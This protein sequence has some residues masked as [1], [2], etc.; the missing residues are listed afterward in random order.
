MRMTED[1]TAEDGRRE[2]AFP[3]SS[4]LHPRSFLQTLDLVVARTGVERYRY[5]CL[6][7]PNSTVRA[8]YAALVVRLAAEAL[9]STQSS[10]VESV[11]LLAVVRS[12]PYRSAPKIG[13]NCGRC[14][15]RGEAR[16]SIRECF[17]CVRT[18]G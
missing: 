4:V 10:T 16:V 11:N 12:C 5:L 6:K 8:E 1:M 17:E 9:G 15:L 7:H 3:Q 2:F 18:N 14:G 13:C